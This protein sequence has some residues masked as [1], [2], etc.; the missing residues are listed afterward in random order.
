MKVGVRHDK[1]TQVGSVGAPTSHFADSVSSLPAA[2]AAASATAE[3][4]TAA[5]KQVKEKIAGKIVGAMPSTYPGAIAETTK[6]LSEDMPKLKGANFKMLSFTNGMNQHISRVGHTDGEE[7]GK[8]TADVAS[9]MGNGDNEHGMSGSIGL[10]S[11][12]GSQLLISRGASSGI[13]DETMLPSECNDDD[14]N[15]GG[16][17]GGGASSL[18]YSM[19]YRALSLFDDIMKRSSTTL[20]LDT[21]RAERRNLASEAFEVLVTSFHGRHRPTE[22]ENQK[23]ARLAVLRFP[24]SEL[25]DALCQIGVLLKCEGQLRNALTAFDVAME[26]RVRALEV[27]KGT[28]I[29]GGGQLNDPL[30]LEG[31]NEIDAD[32]LYVGFCVLT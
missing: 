4:F 28:M 3:A 25:A 16:G 20:D 9:M 8:V 14:D 6:A 29:T 13:I 19:D 11:G 24:S 7:A 32:L 30:M 17:G 22:T 18:D 2:A 23:M 1:D 31:Y 5:T 21:R 10:G 26:I 12:S 27:V 15:G